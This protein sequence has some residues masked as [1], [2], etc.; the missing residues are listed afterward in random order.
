[1]VRKLHGL[2]RDQLSMDVDSIFTLKLVV[3]KRLEHG[4]RMTVFG[5]PKLW[6][7]MET[8]GIGL[9]NINAVRKLYKYGSKH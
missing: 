1:M 9:K 3:E 7:A 5:P 6:T 8:Q 4:L 2:K